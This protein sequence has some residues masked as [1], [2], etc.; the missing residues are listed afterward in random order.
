MTHHAKFRTIPFGGPNHCRDIAVFRFFKMVAVRHV[1]FLKFRNFNYLRRANM[2]HHA[3][4]HADRSNH[5]GDMAIFRFSKMTAVR[6][7]GFW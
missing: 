2:R 5:C 1:G 3:K 4:F 7:L 6:H